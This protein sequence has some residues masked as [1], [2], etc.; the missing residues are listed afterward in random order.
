MVQL[1]WY[2][3]E[4]LCFFGNRLHPGL[5]GKKKTR[6]SSDPLSRSLL[7]SAQKVKLLEEET[8]VQLDPS[9]VEKEMLLAEGYLT[10]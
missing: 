5:S 1:T 9:R 8:I 2:V 3:T 10:R 6:L 4:F 7:Q